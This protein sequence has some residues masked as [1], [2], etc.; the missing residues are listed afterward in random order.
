MLSVLKGGL[1]LASNSF[2]ISKLLLSEGQPQ[3]SEVRLGGFC[4]N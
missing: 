2:Q 4:G 1:S 3:R